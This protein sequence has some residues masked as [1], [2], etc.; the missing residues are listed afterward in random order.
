MSSDLLPH[1][2]E[3]HALQD[4]PQDNRG[5]LAERDSTLSV[6]YDSR[7]IARHLGWFYPCIWFSPLLT[8]AQ[9]NKSLWF[10]LMQDILGKLYIISLLTTLFVNSFQPIPALSFLLTPQLAEIA[11]QVSQIWT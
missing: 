1:G 7:D 3:S 2:D 4:R 8:N 11:V 10:Q 5:D 9:G 6:R